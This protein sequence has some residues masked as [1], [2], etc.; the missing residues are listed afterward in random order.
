MADGV[1]NPLKSKVVTVVGAGES[2]LAALMLLR[3]KGARVRCSVSDAPDARVRRKILAA[4]ALLEE[5]GHTEGFFRPSDAVV[6]SPGVKPS[7]PAIRI[8]RKLRIPV[9]S[10]PE[11][12]AS[13]VQAPWVAVTGTNGKTTTSTLLWRMIQEMRPCD[14]CGNVGRSFSRS[15]IERGGKVARVV[16]V[17]SF[18]LFYA[19]RFAPRV[20]VILN[21]KPNHLDWHRSLGEYYAAKLKLLEHLGCRGVAVLNADDPEIVR[22][23]RRFPC[24]KI[25]FSLKRL[26]DGA[27]TEGSKVFRSRGGKFAEFLS[28]RRSRLIGAHNRQ[29]VMAAALAASAMGVP[30]KAIQ[31]A[32]DAFRPLPHRIQALGTARGIAFVDDSKSTTVESTRAALESFRGPVVLI[33]GGRP[34]EKRFDPIRATLERRAAYVVLYGEARGLIARQ[35]AGFPL[36]EVR[37]FREAVRRAFRAA[38]PGHTVLLSP[39]CASFDQFSSYAERGEVFKEIYKDLRRKFGS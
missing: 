29:N 16:E 2:G 24:K 3:R 25:W 6:T 1:T 11:L 38:R 13:F 27:F 20:A 18:Q 33:A 28:L 23:A 8:A 10:E 26:R 30:D 7:S 37:G 22:L 34:K 5:G 14:L 39:M 35:L 12:A 36:K 17:S 31:R 15:V 9:W 32:L 19:R 4:G 21:L